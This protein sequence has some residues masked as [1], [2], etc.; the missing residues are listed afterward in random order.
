MPVYAS[1]PGNILLL[2][3]TRRFFLSGGRN[4][5]QYSLHLPTEGWPGWVGLDKCGDGRPAKDSHQSQY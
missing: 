4:H 5:R 1:S 2:R 3:R